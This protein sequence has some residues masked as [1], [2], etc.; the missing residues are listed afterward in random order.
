MQFMLKRNRSPISLLP[1]V[2]TGEDF[3]FPLEAEWSSTPQVKIPTGKLNLFTLSRLLS[4]RFRLTEPADRRLFIP[5]F[6]T[7]MMGPCH[8][9]N[10]TSVKMYFANKLM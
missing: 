10:K 1:P 6:G 3:I 2:G 7:A 9:E 8:F 5:K 4:L